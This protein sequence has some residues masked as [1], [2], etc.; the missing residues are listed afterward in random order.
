MWGERMNGRGGTGRLA[1]QICVQQQ[2][3]PKDGAYP[4]TQQRAPP[5]TE[6]V[7]SAAR[8]SPRLRW[9]RR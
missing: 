4:N 9:K 6:L 1:A 3:D 5:R 2:D 8:S 7:S